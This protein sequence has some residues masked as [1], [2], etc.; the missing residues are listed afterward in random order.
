[1]LGLAE[2]ALAEAAEPS[3]PLMK[4]ALQPPWGTT[5]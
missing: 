4:F 1:M 5:L 2:A 3:V